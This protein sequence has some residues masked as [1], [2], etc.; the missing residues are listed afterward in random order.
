MVQISSLLVA[1]TAASV[2]L[3]APAAFQKRINQDTIAAKT[4]WEAACD[5]AGG[6]QKCN[7]IAVTAAGTLLANAGDCAQQ[8][9]ADAMITLA[10]SLK[11]DPDMISLAQIFAQQPRNSPNSVSIPYCQTAPKNSELN[12][13][14]QCQF[15]GVDPKNFVGGLKPG[16]KGTLPLGKTSLNP[17]GSCPAHTSGPV[18]DGVQLNT[19]VTS[20]GSG[21]ASSGSGSGAKAAPSAT[22]SAKKAKATPAATNNA[23]TSSG[24]GSSSGGFQLQN[25]KD[26]Q[27]LNAS[28][29]SLSESSSCTAGQQ[30]C[31]NGG[32]AQCVGS[33]FVVTGCGAGT[34]CAA[35]PL[36]NSAGTS[37]TCTTDADAT[38][39]IA[40]TGATGGLTGN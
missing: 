21:A 20:P 2:A 10:K 34:T 27:K 8:D 17:A 36:V 14:F 25:G 26:A 16:D 30:A 37:I 24:S 40:A 28:F 23:A 15:S 3:A 13:L 7:P 35:L 29:K 5:K 4:K 19:L 32:F 18:A 9:S 22:S 1:L 31:I 33:K 12:G 11:N 39:R 6:G 38:A